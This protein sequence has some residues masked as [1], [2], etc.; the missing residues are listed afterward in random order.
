MLNKLAILIMIVGFASPAAAWTQEKVCNEG[1]AVLDSQTISPSGGLFIKEL[2]LVIRDAGVVEYFKT[3]A[4]GAIAKYYASN[5][6]DK[7][8]LIVN[9][10]RFNTQS[11]LIEGETSVF[12]T[13]AGR[14]QGAVIVSLVNGGINVQYLEIARDKFG[15]VWQKTE[16]ANWTFESCE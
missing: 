9:G 3:A 15:N 2:Q 12:Q 1:A 11:A 10:F 5:F 13:E 4:D 6:N 16:L 7:S 8:E 14:R